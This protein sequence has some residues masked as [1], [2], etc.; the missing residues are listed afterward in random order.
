MSIN[1]DQ[2]IAFC[3]GSTVISCSRY[4]EAL[5]RLE[6]ANPR[7]SRLFNKSGAI[8]GRAIVYNNNFIRACNCL[9]NALKRHGEILP[10]VE[11]WDNQTYLFI[12]RNALP[13]LI[14]SKTMVNAACS[15]LS[16]DATLVCCRRKSTP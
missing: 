4:P 5:L 10:F 11:G 8:I 2:N 14:T 16:A 12:H 13:I 15:F 7:I 3:K 1:K 9:L 6:Q